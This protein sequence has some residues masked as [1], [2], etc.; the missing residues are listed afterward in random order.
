[1]AAAREYAR[2]RA[3]PGAYG[4][5]VSVRPRNPQQAARRA[6]TPR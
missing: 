3:C 2:P 4:T 6:L 1:M 5:P